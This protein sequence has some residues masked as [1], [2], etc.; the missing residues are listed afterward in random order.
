MKRVPSN[1]RGHRV[2]HGIALA[3]I[4]LGAIATI[5][6]GPVRVPTARP[7]PVIATIASTQRQP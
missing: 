3:V 5:M 7:T 1:A 2:I 6:S 4:L